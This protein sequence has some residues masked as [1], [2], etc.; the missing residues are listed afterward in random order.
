MHKSQAFF[1]KFYDTKLDNWPHEE[2]PAGA[3]C[4]PDLASIRLGLPWYPARPG[5]DP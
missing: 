4:L 3:K 1:V 2:R 5:L